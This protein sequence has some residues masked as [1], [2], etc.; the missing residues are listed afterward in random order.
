MCCIL[1]PF[2]NLFTNKSV[3][4]AFR[5]TAIDRPFDGTEKNT[6][7]ENESIIYYSVYEYSEV[8]WILQGKMEVMNYSNY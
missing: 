6:K 2:S 4:L 7:L 1:N 3:V 8:R 5:S